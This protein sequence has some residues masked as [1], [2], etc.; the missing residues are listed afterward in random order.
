LSYPG[1]T[2]T[3]FG[4]YAVS[5]PWRPELIHWH[6]AET[7]LTEVN[8]QIPF[9]PLDQEDLLKQGIFTDEL[10]P[11]AIRAD[12]LGSCTANASMASLGER[13]TAAG[14]DLSVAGLSQ[15][16]VNNEKQAIRFYHATTFQ[17]GNPAQEWPPQDCGSTGLFCCTELERQELITSYQTATG[18]LN[19]LSLLQGG[20]VIM[21][22]PWF[23][24]WMN[25]DADGFVDGDGSLDAL[26]AAAASGIAG[27]HETC[28][29]AIPQ[30][31]QAAD[32]QVDLQQT[33]IQVRNSWSDQFALSGDYRLHASTLEYLAGQFDFKMFVVK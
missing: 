4:Q 1:P 13:L 25:P 2:P 28:A 7:T 26:Q 21:G 16:V 17:T 18:A 22:G 27:G 29:R 19:L 31:A 20:T 30:L 10:I 8:H 23:M 11:G 33:V 12:A 15:D 3:K 14:K 32:G 5:E 24:S 6:H 9:G